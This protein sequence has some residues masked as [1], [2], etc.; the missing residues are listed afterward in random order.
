[1]LCIVSK[2]HEATIFLDLCQITDSGY[3]LQPEQSSLFL[4][5][6]QKDLSLEN[7]DRNKVQFCGN[8]L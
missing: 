3:K 2:C 8:L 1:M 6:L 4:Y 7:E 5:N